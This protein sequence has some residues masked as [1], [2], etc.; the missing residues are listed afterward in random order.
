[1]PDETTLLDELA[2]NA[3]AAPTVQ[4]VDGW[5]LRAAAALPFRRSSC[6]LP[7]GGPERLAD[8][9]L[10]ARLATVRDFYARRG[11]PA[12]FQVGAAPRP[13]DLD[14]VLAARGW[15]VE[16]PVDVFVAPSQE[17]AARTRREPRERLLV[18]VVRGVDPGWI[19]RYADA[20]AHDDATR[21]RVRAYG[22]LL[23]GIGPPVVTVAASVE[24]DPAGVGFGVVERGWLGVF[25]MGTHAAARRRGVATAVL[26]ALAGVAR[27]DGAERMYLQVE[28]DNVGARALYARAGFARS[29]GY[30]YRTLAAPEPGPARPA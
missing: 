1:V 22:R 29:Y 7:W 25:G 3:T 26:H 15:A 27:D 10:D 8:A 21:R 23:A 20:H 9:D 28:R 30:H 4:L 2:A 6:V 18:E 19:G 5:I 14:G 13:V 11:L 24:D 17:V 12:R 16:T